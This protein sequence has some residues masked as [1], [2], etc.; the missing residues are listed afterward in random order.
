MKLDIWELNTM[1]QGARVRVFL[2]SQNGQNQLAWQFDVQP[3]STSSIY[4]TTEL[5]L[6][7]ECHE[8]TIEFLGEGHGSRL[9]GSIHVP[10]D[11]LITNHLLSDEGYSIKTTI[12][13]DQ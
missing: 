11:E 2:R 8:I 6:T 3:D 1:K 10:I 9:I 5:V 7:A 13:N 12:G 4:E